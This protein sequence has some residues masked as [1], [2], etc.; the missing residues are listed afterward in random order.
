MSLCSGALVA[1]RTSHMRLRTCQ[2][3]DE[4]AI[5]GALR[6]GGALQLPEQ[7]VH[8]GDVPRRRTHLR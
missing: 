2:A 8:L 7:D 1:W 4:G 3:G 5:E 6:C